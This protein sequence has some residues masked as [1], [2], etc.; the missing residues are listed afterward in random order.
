MPAYPAMPGITVD[1]MRE[2]DRLMVEVYGIG[3]AQ[4]MEHAGRNLAEL[5]RMLLGGAV[6]GKSV[7]IAAGKGNN[8]GGGLVAARHL[9]NWGAGMTVLVESSAALRDVPLLQWQSMHRL[10]ARREE[11][12]AALETMSH[13]QADLVIDALIGYGLDAAP[14]GWIGKMI[15]HINAQAA[16][17]LALDVPS[18]LDATTGRAYTPC[19]KA[20][21]TMTL[22]LPKI[23]LLVPEARPYV[24][25]L[26]LADIGVPPVLYAHLG[27]E[28]GPI[29][30]REPL[31]RLA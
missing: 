21:T 27:L 20:A 18:G 24:G 8:G 13:A 29:F 11:G 31:V 14:H 2:V 4:M 16:P 23:G 9:S 26:F 30:A 6:A 3:L 10:P 1:Q 25:A 12:S 22:A 5:A 7:L 15:G 17:V 19:V 28:V